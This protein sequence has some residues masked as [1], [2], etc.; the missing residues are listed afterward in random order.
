MIFS[1]NN[2]CKPQLSQDSAFM[3][4]EN[5]SSGWLYRPVSYP[6]RI[7]VESGKRLKCLDVAAIVY[8]KAEGDYTVIYTQEGSY[9]SSYGIGAIENKLDPRLFMRIHR[10]FIVNINCIKELYRDITRMFL[11]LDNGIEINVGRHY[12]HAIRRMIF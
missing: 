1:G 9:L 2:E 7:L 8:L 5:A 11:V 10:S 6:A 4:P 3:L 12:V